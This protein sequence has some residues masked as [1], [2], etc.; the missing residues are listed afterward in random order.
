MGASSGRFRK[1]DIVAELGLLLHQ[2]GSSSKLDYGRGSGGFLKA[3]AEA[4]H[5]LHRIDVGVGGR[6]AEVAQACLEWRS[7]RPEDE[8]WEFLQGV[9]A[10]LR[11]F[12]EKLEAA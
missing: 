4:R 3:K 5:T 12:E 6:Y 7:T 2:I 1:A 9:V 10:W 8:G 11:D